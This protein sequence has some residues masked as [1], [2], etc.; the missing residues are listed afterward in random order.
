MPTV[1]ETAQ[2][3]FGMGR[4]NPMTMIQIF[5]EINSILSMF[6]SKSGHAAE[7]VYNFTGQHTDIAFVAENGKLNASEIEKIPDKQL[8][9]N[10]QKSFSDA[11]QDGYLDYDAKTRDFSVTQ[12]GM[13]HINSD[14]FMTQFE[15]DQRGQ[16]AGN[17][18]E[19][20]LRGNESDL[21]VF[22]FTDSINLQSIASAYPAESERIVKYFKECE[23]Y[24][25]VH[26]SSDGIAT[27]TEKCLAYLEQNPVENFDIE[28]V[29]PDN[30]EQVVD[31][32]IERQVANFYDYEQNGKINAE[33]KAEGAVEYKNIT[34]EQAEY[35]RSVKGEQGLRFA[36]F[37]AVPDTG[38]KV[39]IGGY[40]LVFAKSD[41]DKF[42]KLLTDL[43]SRK[44]REQMPKQSKKEVPRNVLEN[45]F[46]NVAFGAETAKKTVDFVSGN[47]SGTDAAADSARMAA[48]QGANHLRA[49][50]EK[51]AREQAAK[52][53]AAKAAAQ[54]GA[55]AAA[56]TGSTAAGAAS[57]G[58]GAAVSVIVDLSAK[59][60]NVLT[61]LN[62][63]NKR[64]T[65][66]YRS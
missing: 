3:M 59:G 63:Q 22:R 56:K 28:K 20:K 40:N 44:Q 41:S 1:D 21:N 60:A 32:V 65:L 4:M 8:R 43:E 53:A 42:S 66:Q 17:K 25:F 35:L 13:E 30:L 45:T 7:S 51:K 27:P 26:I 15:K 61:N 33:L 39:K 49:M 62:T 64:P 5:R 31:K 34:A 38:N 50:A 23:K 16:I 47:S 10:V 12:K 29:S 52:R 9:E 19:V 54:A 58:I 57:M 18:A 37:D 48:Q 36:I 11:V 24:G 2:A 46:E 14:A 6:K 55:K